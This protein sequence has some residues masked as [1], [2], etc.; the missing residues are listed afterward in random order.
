[1]PH[2]LGFYAKIYWRCVRI[3]GRQELASHGVPPFF[4]FKGGATTM[5]DVPFLTRFR[6]E[7]ERTK[8]KKKFGKNAREKEEKMERK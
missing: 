5:F 3:K 4:L 7:N 8:T 2:T 6:F 1:M